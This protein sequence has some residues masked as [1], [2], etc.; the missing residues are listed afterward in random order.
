MNIY[1]IDQKLMELIDQ[2][3][4]EL[5]D[6]EAFEALSIER[7]KKIENTALWVKNLEAYAAA[8]KAEKAALNERQ[9]KAEARAE[10]LR[11]FLGNILAGEKFTTAKV[12]CT[13][14]SS[15][16]LEVNE[17]F[18]Q[19]AM[20]NDADMYL[21]YKAPEVDKPAVTNALKQG[22]DIPHAALV[23]RQSMTIK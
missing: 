1:E 14:R 23:Q 2:E 10:K 21:R 16:A 15:T 11:A 13:F 18:I 12:S 6:Y 7:D 19:W 3:T 9:K 5:M 22:A 20:E 8:I 4:G 17:E